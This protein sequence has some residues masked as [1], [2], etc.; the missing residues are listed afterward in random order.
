WS[1]GLAACS[2][3][4]GATA[5]ISFQSWRKNKGGRWSSGACAAALST[6]RKGVANRSRGI[7][8]FS[9]FPFVEHNTTTPMIDVQ[10]LR[11]QYGDLTAVDGVSFAA[12]PGAIFGLLGL[13]G[14][15]KSTTIGC[16]SGLIKPS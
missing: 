2:W 5:A 16:I 12:A 7:G 1:L 14:A 9:P 6:I 3:V 8:R 10:D 4:T 13:N 15:G 11:K